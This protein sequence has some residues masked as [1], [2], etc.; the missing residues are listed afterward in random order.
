VLDHRLPYPSL[1]RGF[2]AAAARW[3]QRIIIKDDGR[4]TSYAVLEQESRRAARALIAHGLQPGDRVGIWAVNHTEWV[5]AGLAIQAA[6]GVII[7]L[8]TRLRGREIAEILRRSG[9]SILI[10]DPGFGGYDFAAAIEA[11]SIP[12]LR[13]IVRLGDGPAQRAVGWE[14]FLAAG[15]ATPGA[16]VEERIAAVNP[17]TVSDII[18]T[19][20]TTGTPKGVPMTH[21]QS[22]IA[23]EQQQLCCSQFEEGD[24]FAV[25][26]PFAH[27]AGYRAG[28]QASLL[29]GIPFIPVRSYDPLDFLQLIQREGVTILPAVPTVFQGILDHAERPRYDLS[30]IRRAMTGATTIPVTLIERMQAEF[31][32][33]AVAAGYGLTETAGSVSST[34]PGDTAQVIATTTG[35]PLDNLEVKLIDSEGMDVPKGEAG[36]IVVRGPQ[37]MRAYYLDE[38]A[39]AAAFTPDGFLRTG[40]VGVFD[41]IGNLR[42]TDRIKDMYIVGGFNTYPVEVEQ[43]LAR[44]EGVAEAAVI[45]I[46][47]ERLGQVGKAFIVPRPGAELDEAAVIA[48]CRENM[49]NYKVPRVVTF[50]D[51]LPRTASGKVSKVELRN[52]S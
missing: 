20:G 51:G 43:Q 7:P 33:D 32:V 37:V 22:L 50:V 47:D 36:E 21:G 14:T 44:I 38:A 40:D 29:F 27:N 11:E 25:T 9:A 4:E 6:G 8:S 31:G 41:E 5:I 49:A 18:F 10:C 13:H 17:E 39:T 28:W 16:M 30:S 42:I 34:R 45:G 26:Y 23:C 24:L 19:S 3:P 15:E 46:P 12:S 48:W 52:L 1:Y 2:Q 35:K